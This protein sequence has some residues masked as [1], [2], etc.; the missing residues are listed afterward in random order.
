MTIQLTNWAL[1]T[2]PVSHVI[3]TTAEVLLQILVSVVSTK[4]EIDDLLALT[5]RQESDCKTEDD[6]IMSNSVTILLGKESGSLSVLC[7]LCEGSTGAE[8]EVVR[9]DFFLMRR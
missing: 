9:M 8:P 6:A 7:H 3:T 2:S 5:V 1:P 4:K